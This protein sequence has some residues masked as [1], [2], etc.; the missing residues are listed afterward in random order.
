MKVDKATFIE[1]KE[2]FIIFLYFFFYI[3]IFAI[4]A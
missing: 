1:Y 2:S 4:I 3:I